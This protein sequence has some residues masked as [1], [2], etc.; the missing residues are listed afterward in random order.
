MTDHTIILFSNHFPFR[1]CP[2]S[3]SDYQ[4][5]K[6]RCE[7]ELQTL[8]EYGQFCETFYKVEMDKKQRVHTYKTQ[9]QNNQGE[10]FLTHEQYNGSQYVFCMM[11]DDDMNSCLEYLGIIQNI[12]SHLRV[13]FQDFVPT[14]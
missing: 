3:D 4:I 9:Y 10:S 13:F 5:M 1:E 12:Q 2:L 7:L 8:L 6:C 14:P 11:V